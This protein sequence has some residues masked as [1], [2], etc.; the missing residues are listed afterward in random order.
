MSPRPRFMLYSLTLRQVPAELSLVSTGSVE[1]VATA[2]QGLQVVCEGTN[3][4][5]EYASSLLGCALNN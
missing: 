3:L 1:P 4:V 2:A 5:I